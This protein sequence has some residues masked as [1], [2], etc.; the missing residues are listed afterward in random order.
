MIASSILFKGFS[1]ERKGLIAKEI[2]TSKQL[3]KELL[4]VG[5]LGYIRK[6]YIK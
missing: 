6:E 2:T 1:K 3:Q 5:V 4:K